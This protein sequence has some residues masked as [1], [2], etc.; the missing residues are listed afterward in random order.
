MA[1]DKRENQCDAEHGTEKWPYTSRCVKNRH[2]GRHHVD[3][4]GKEWI[5]LKPTAA[6]V[7]ADSDADGLREIVRGEWAHLADALDAECM[8]KS[9]EQR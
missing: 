8:A 1:N 4:H 9:M 3:R 7:W 5:D 2:D 6:E